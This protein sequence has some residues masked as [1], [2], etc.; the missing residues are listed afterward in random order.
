MERHLFVKLEYWKNK[1][2]RKPLIIQGAR[3]VGKTW[4]MKEFGARYYK[5][6]IYI[7]FDNNETMKKVFE[8]DFDISRIIS[9]IKIEYGKSFVP[10]ETLIIFDEIQEAPKALASLK[11]FYENAPQYS[12]MAAGSLFGVALHQGTSFP[13]GK[14]DFMHLYPLN[15]YEFV[16]AIGEKQLAE[17][18]ESGD[19]EMINAFSTKYTELLKKYYYIGGMP[20]VVQTYIDTY[21][22]YEV[23][24]IQ[25]NLLK[26]YEE[27]FSKHASKEVVPR[28]MMVWNSI[29]SQLAKQ[30][31]K[32]IYG[33]MREGA[34]AKDF[35]LAIQWLED[36][37]LII[38]S[39]RIAK[40]DIPL[41][42]YMEMNS[43]KMFTL[44]VGLLGAK[45][46]I[47]AKVLLDG[48]RI[49][50]EFKG[51]LTEQFVAQQLKA[52]DR[53]LYYY[54]TENS[55]GEIDF[56]IQQEMQC[57]PIEVKAEENLRARSLR[58]FCEKYKPETAIRSSMSDYREQDW[59][60]NVPLYVLDKYLDRK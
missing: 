59:M 10:E 43:F 33:C 52:S 3:Q 4:I 57:I 31:R 27:D 13:V 45:A 34:R 56:V 39:Y 36:A 26:Y 38:R 16:C 58:A 2:K 30:N 49:F 32:F 60:V 29:P 19:Y 20:E 28:I 55:S 18:L 25:K 40:P 7:N 44:D 47:H 53:E 23:R 48:C 22:F 8:I 14:V 54:S 41:I 46:N 1:K 51:A 24:E 5:D 12:I 37:G 6:T 9:F 15:F 50:E 42:A 35:E 21:D 11:Y 17:L